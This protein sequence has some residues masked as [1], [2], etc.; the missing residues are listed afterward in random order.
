MPFM[1]PK[2]ASKLGKMSKGKPRCRY[3]YSLRDFAEA[4]GMSHEALKKAVHRK[5]LDPHDLR[6]FGLFFARRVLGMERG[7]AVVPD[8]AD[9][10]APFI[11]AEEEIAV[12]AQP[13]VV[14]LS[15]DEKIAMLKAA[16]ARRR[17]PVLLSA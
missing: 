7:L 11:P 9:E 13:A 1:S 4:L 14:E 3:R 6:T 2:L 16:H 5:Q 10:N 15:K 12:V 17:T 8:L